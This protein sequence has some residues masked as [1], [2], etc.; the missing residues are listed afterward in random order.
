MTVAQARQ[1]LTIAS[2]AATCTL[3]VF[4]VLAPGNFYSLDPSDAPRLMQII[5]PVFLGYLGAIAQYVIGAGHDPNVSLRGGFVAELM[6]KGPV[7]IFVLGMSA[8]LLA[9]QLD[10][11]PG[12]RGLW[13][14]DQLALYVTGALSVLTVSTN[15]II[16]HLFAQIGAALPPTALP[17]PAPPSS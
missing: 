10:Q 1:W 7:V 3:F 2:L 11:R 15:V 16:S 13:T 5:L 17:P 9:F 4:L 6:V 8:I 12:G 14:V